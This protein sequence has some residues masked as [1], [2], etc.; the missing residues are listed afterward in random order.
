[1]PN[2]HALEVGSLFLVLK[3]CPLRSEITGDVCPGKVDRSVEYSI[4]EIGGAPDFHSAEGGLLLLVP[5]LRLICFVPGDVCRDK[6]DRSVEY[7][8]LEI[9]GAPDFHALEIGLCLK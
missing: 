4:L 6:V 3:L 7:S 5:I 2:F 8:I 9:G 1:M